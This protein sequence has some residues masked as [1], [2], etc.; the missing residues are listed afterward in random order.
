VVLHNT[1]LMNFLSRYFALED[2]QI[3]KLGRIHFIRINSN[4][5]FFFEFDFFSLSLRIIVSTL[6]SNSKA[7]EWTFDGLDILMM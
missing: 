1:Y 5:I 6:G 4:F 2:I 7:D 3:I